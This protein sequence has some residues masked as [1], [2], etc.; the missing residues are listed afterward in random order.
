MSVRYDG[1]M[2]GRFDSTFRVLRPS[3]QARLEQMRVVD[4]S[5]SR[6]PD[7]TDRER[8]RDFLDRIEWALSQR[9]DER[10]RAFLQRWVA[11]RIGE[12]ATPESLVQSVVAI[13][14][15]VT[16]VGRTELPAGEAT[17][18]FIREIVRLELFCA[19]TIVSGL[20]D[21]LARLQARRQ[22]RSRAP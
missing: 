17:T 4:V 15:A 6:A 9:D 5:D 10:Y 3:I 21:E 18:A 8:D 13:Y 11:M 12:G 1:R 19:R 2:N 7:A 16:K 14:D 22:E 20:A